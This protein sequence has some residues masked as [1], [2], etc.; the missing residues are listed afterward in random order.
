MEMSLSSRALGNG[1]KAMILTLNDCNEEDGS[2]SWQTMN[3][4]DLSLVTL[5]FCILLRINWRKKAWIRYG[6]LRSEAGGGQ[7]AG[8]GDKT[9]KLPDPDIFQRVKRKVPG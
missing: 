9:E 5:F 8:P 4:L 7:Q 6:K 3:V 2:F 1:E